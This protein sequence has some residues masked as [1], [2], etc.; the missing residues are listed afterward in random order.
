MWFDVLLNHNLVAIRDGSVSVAGI[1]GEPLSIRE[2]AS[3]VLVTMRHPQTELADDLGRAMENGAAG[4]IQ[5]VVAV[6]DCRAP[7][8]ISEAVFR[9]TGRRARLTKPIRDF[10][11]ASNRCLRTSSHRNGGECA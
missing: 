5:N 4:T 8:L 3:V 2:A 11:S 9:E 7:G 10:L 1:F 6:G